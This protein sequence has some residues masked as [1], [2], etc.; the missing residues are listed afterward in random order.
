MSRTTPNPWIGVNFIPDNERVAAPPAY[1]LQRLFDF[2]AML[3]LLPSRL[4]PFA[5]IIAR[6]RQYS[7]G[8]T[9]KA[10]DSTI[11]QPDT[12]LCMAHGLVP[13]SLMYKI[14]PTWNIDPVLASLKARDTWAVGGGDKAADLMDAED[15][16]VEAANKKLVRDD[17]WNRSGDAYRSYKAR[18]GQSI[19]YRPAAPSGQRISNAPLTSGS[20][21]GLGA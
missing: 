3:V 7:A 4:V 13:V 6:R 14:G 10:L 8:Y 18:T 17:M 12:K 2:D 16:K 11:D 1:V 5:Y 20:T 9:D 21:A 15:A 19:G